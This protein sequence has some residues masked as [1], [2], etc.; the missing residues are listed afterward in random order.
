MLEMTKPY[1][2]NLDMSQ[3]STGFTLAFDV[4]YHHHAKEGETS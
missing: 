2:K 3:F 4:S 1:Q